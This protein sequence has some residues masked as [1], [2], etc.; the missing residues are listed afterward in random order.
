MGDSQKTVRQ[1]L[2]SAAVTFVAGIVIVIVTS[3]YTRNKPAPKKEEIVKQKI[4]PAKTA[5][6]T[7]A[8]TPS[9]VPTQTLE[10]YKIEILNGTGAPG[11]ASQ[12]KSLFID[13]GFSNLTTDNAD[14][15]DHKD[16]LVKLK[17]D[18]PEVVFK[19]IKEALA[20]Y[21]VVKGDDLSEKEDYDAIVIVGT[22]KASP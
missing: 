3:Y 19:S 9:P 6:P 11:V 12:A 20:E 16:T 18:I 2:I 7:V 13:A 17:T 22:K 21:T 10:T 5:V 14:S 1:F 8:H 4:L 15:F